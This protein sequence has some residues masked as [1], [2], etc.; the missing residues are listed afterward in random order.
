[1]RKVMILKS[2][3][4]SLMTIGVMMLCCTSQTFGQVPP[5][6]DLWLGYDKI[7]NVDLLHQ[8]EQAAA[9]IYFQNNS[10]ILKAARK[11]LK[12]GLG[13]MLDRTV[14]FTDSFS[15]AN[16]MVIAK[17]ASLDKAIMK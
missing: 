4:T 12:R 13:S 15:A 8:Y 2:K 7:E 3:L 17:K 1:M 9:S 10:E 14:D 11:E 6:Y 16:S 5:G